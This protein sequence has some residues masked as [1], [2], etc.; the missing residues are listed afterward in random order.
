MIEVIWHGR[1]GQ[2]AFTAA[3]L[4]GAAYCSDRTDARALAFPSFGPERR[5]APMRAF[6]KLSH[7][8]IGDRAASTTGDIVVY[9]DETLLD[10]GFASELKEGGVVLV[11][12]PSVFD[13]GRI[14]SLDASGISA[15]ILGRPIPNTALLGALTLLIE[16]L[17]RDDVVAAVKGYMPTRLQ[18]VNVKVVDAAI[19]S[20]K[21][22]LG[23]DQGD[24]EASAR[25]DLA[26]AS[27]G[28]VREKP[29]W[30]NELDDEIDIPRLEAGVPVPR[31]F[32]GMTCFTSGYLTTCNAG[33][34]Q[35]RPVVD[36]AKCRA[37]M[38]CYLHCPD[39][40]IRKTGARRGGD[41][42][43]VFVDYDFCKGC[44]ICARICPF[45]AIEMV[46]ERED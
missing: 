46:P 12:S 20:F 9:L 33:W 13:D 42:A 3:R 43:A 22:A 27:D 8:R 18:E 38:K 1:G 45:D 28:T 11:N 36:A 44:G 32:D 25:V 30:R 29:A 40:T 14:H 31:S 17:T 5:G 15:S 26:A 39:G 41:V 19:E 24:L 6:T 10:D 16:D 21:A 7:G 34:R 37:C 4:L 2:G 35:K 23:R